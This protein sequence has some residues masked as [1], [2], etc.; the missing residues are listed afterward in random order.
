MPATMVSPPRTSGLP[1]ARATLDSRLSSSR[2][3]RPASPCASG[4]G[5]RGGLRGGEG[6]VIIGMIRY[7]FDVLDVPDGI[8]PVQYENRAAL[9]AQVLDQ[10]PIRFPE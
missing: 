9:D 5:G 6:G 8:V 4:R 1:A 2:P 3:A 7:L 10:G